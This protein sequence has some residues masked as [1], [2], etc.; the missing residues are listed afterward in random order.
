MAE[1]TFTEGEAYAL[2]A[3]AVER[4]TAAAKA[5]AAT[6]LEQV[7]TVSNE[8]DALLLRATAAE[9]AKA[10]AE[11]ALADYKESVETQKAQEAKRSDRVAA[12]AEVAPDLKIEGERAERVVAM[13]DDAFTD[14]VA[15]LREVAAMSFHPFKKAASGSKCSICDADDTAPMHKAAPQKAGE[16]PRQSAAFT[17]AQPG[18]GSSTTSPVK[19]LFAAR[20]AASVPAR[21]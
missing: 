9:E 14:Y 2:V 4:E 3:D 10:A 12:L 15:S 1:R 5:Q 16:L 20:R 8:K 19:G 17:G 7:T 18:A 21:T 11:Q 6:A 13:A